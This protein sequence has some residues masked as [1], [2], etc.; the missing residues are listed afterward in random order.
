MDAESIILMADA[1]AV[2]MAALRFPTGISG[3]C[4]LC[5]VLK[6][7]IMKVGHHKLNL[8]HSLV[9]NLIYKLIV[10]WGVSLVAPM[11]VY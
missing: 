6:L 11:A 1:M 9:L 7:D 5:R 3:W 4:S 2:P 8:D 10:Y